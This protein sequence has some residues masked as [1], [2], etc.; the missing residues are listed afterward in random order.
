M[1]RYVRG[2]INDHVLWRM[3]KVCTPEEDAALCEAT[4]LVSACARLSVR[5]SAR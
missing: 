4:R 3:T 2:T 5:F 1:P